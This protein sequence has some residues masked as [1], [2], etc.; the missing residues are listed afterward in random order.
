MKHQD[1]RQLETELAHFTGTTR[2]YRIDR[3][4]LLTDGTHHLAERALCYWLMYLFSSYLI[5]LK[6]DDW[7]TVL[8]F[9]VAGASANV[10]IEDGN[11]HVLATQQIEYTNFPLPTIK[12]YG[13]WDGEQWVLMLPSEY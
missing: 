3:K 10:I 4:T 1:I 9:D 8:K 6:L 11:D 13:C 7:F 5:E 12:L 2:Y